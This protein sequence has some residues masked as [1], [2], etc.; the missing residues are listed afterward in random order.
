MKNLLGVAAA[1]VL[2]A[3]CGRSQARAPG[4]VRI[5]DVPHIKQKP[6]FCGEAC[7]A[8][9]LQK[10]GHDYSQDDVFNRSGLDPAKGRGC[11]TAEMRTALK[12]IGF[13]IGPVWHQVKVRSQASEIAAQWKALYKD[14]LAGIPSIVCMRYDGAEKTTE[15]FRLIVGFDAARDEVVYHEPAQERGAYRGMK[16]ATFLSLWPLKYRTDT[17]TLIRMRLKPGTIKPPPAAVAGRDDA[18]YAQ[19]IQALKRKLPGPGFTIVLQKPFVVV[20]DESSVMVRRRALST[21]KWS[22]DHLKK[23]YFRSDPADLYTIWLF[24]DKDSYRTNARKLWGDEPTTPFGYASHTNKALVMNIGTGGGTLVHE[25]VHPFIHVNF[26]DC[27]AWFNEGLASLYEQ[28]GERR[29]KIMG[30]TNWRLAG[31][32]KAI[33]ANRVPSFKELTGTSEH[34]FY[35]ED[36]GT[37]YSQA[38]YL[39]YYLQEKGLLQKFY[40]AFVAGHA[41]DKSGFA[42]LK[43]VLGVDDMAAFQKVWQAWVMKLSFR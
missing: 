42:T 15:H 32:Q 18:A 21:V 6:D 29:G 39:C 38:R 10:L 27:P 16:R 41:E 22:V 3:G 43:S 8:M 7:A 25:I 33:Q 30:F 20:G 35:D 4:S 26:P 36:K 17:W 14:L 37:N 1:L 40:R 9:Y 24:R 5:A 28:C 2:S 13:E 11:H 12:Q 19:H 34:E 31:L 23:S